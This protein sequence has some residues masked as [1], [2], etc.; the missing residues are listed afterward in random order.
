MVKA[1]AKRV[2]DGIAVTRSKAHQKLRRSGSIED[3]ID[4]DY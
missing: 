1:G 2:E 3:A 4:F